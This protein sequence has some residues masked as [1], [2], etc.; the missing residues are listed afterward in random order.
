MSQPL[1][2]ITLVWSAGSPL[3]IDEML[4]ENM[5]RLRKEADR[6]CLKA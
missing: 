4:F 5:L 6:S 1:W 2:Q 3:L